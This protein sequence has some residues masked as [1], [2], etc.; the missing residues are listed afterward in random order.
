MGADGATSRVRL[1]AGA[2]DLHP[3]RYLAIQEWVEGG[4][5]PFPYFTSLFDP[6]I[7][8]YYCWTIPKEDSLIVGAAL[9]PE[10]RPGERF[11]LLKRRLKDYGFQIG[12][13]IRKEGA[14]I[15]RPM[16]TK[17]LLTGGKG[18]ALIG[19]AA[20]WISP[21]SA[22]GL[23]YALKSAVLLAESLRP[24]PMGFEK[25]YAE[26]TQPLRRN[27]FLKAIKS[28]FLFNPVLRKAV[29]RSGLQSMKI[30]HG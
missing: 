12:K 8:D 6:E 25:R 10:Q 29:M 30:S 11:D 26:R 22:E 27:L 18:V 17:Q 23:S 19:E 16:K 14:F 21:S 13:T 15:L 7:T 28:H 2:P 5:H 1:Q 4:G 3:R 24:A 20:G 9:R